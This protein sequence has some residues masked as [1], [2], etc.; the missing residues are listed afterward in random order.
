M[1]KKENF[2]LPWNSVVLITVNL[3]AISSI[4]ITFN[5]RLNYKFHSNF[6]YTAFTKFLLMFGGLLKK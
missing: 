5:K 6:F 3:N 4:I 1:R 2:Y